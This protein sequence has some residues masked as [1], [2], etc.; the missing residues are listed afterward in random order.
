MLRPK[1]PNLLKKVATILLVFFVLLNIMAAFQAYRMTYFYEQGEVPFQRFPDKT[2]EQKIQTI[3][4]GAKIPKREMTDKPANSF[5]VVKLTDSEGYVLEGWYVPVQNPKGTVALFHGH[6]S[7]KS[8][9]VREADYFHQLGFNTFALDVRSHGNSQGNVCTVGYSESEGIK[10]V[11]DWIR[12]KGEKNLILWGV[13]M[14]ASMLLKAVPAYDLKPQK[15]ILNCPFASMHD[16]VKGFLRNMKIPATPLAEMLMFYGSVERN[17]WGFDYEPAEYAK[18]IKNIPILLQ[19]GRKDLRVQQQETDLIFKNLGTTNK[20]LVIYED[21]GHE[22]FCKKEI[23]KW[24]GVV[25]GF[26]E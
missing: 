6:A 24:E 18:N 3:L 8:Q 12:K 17:Y 13:S 1:R 11:Y 5:E 25:K 15:I 16:A 20:Q 26:L 14:G 10:L 2:I 7:S 22:S 9:V 21:S 23:L 19:W 4:F